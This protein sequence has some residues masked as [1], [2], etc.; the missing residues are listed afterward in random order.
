MNK[1]TAVIIL[2]I[3]AV[4][5]AAGVYWYGKRAPVVVEKRSF[6]VIAVNPG[7]AAY[8]KFFDGFKEAIAGINGKNDADVS[9]IFKNAEGDA[10]KLKEL[11]TAAVVMKPDIIATISGPP[12]LQALNET[13]A[14]KIPILTALGDPVEHG[15]VKSLQSSETNLTGIAQQ[16]IELTPK[17]FEILK[18]LVPAVKRVAVFY[19]TGCG[20][21][22]KARPIAN[23]A[24]PVLG[25]TLTEFPLTDPTRDEVAGAL[26]AVNK[27]DFDAIIFYP[28]G[29]LFSKSDLFLKR[30]AEEKLPII[31]PDE[32]SL[33]SGALASYGPDYFEMGKALGRMAEKIIIGG[34]S[35]ENIP[36]EQP[37]KI[38]FIINLAG[39]KKLGIAIPEAVLK[40]ADRIVE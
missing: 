39:A 17:R 18:E 34:E 10:K 15:Y 11:V 33:A 3:A 36:L 24:A 5:A 12:T 2:G 21:T 19:D 9:L 26:G 37:S 28:H 23:A 4:A 13:K 29:T 27:R 6:L 1:K 14:S 32:E 31:M 25:L 7:G 8:T 40:S 16:N 35:P 30:A 20:P 38:N 22:K